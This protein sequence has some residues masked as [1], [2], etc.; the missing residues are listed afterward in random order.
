MVIFHS[1]VS[2]PEGQCFIWPAMMIE[3]YWNIRRWM[4]ELLNIHWLVCQYRGGYT[5]WFINLEYFG[6]YW[7]LAMNWLLPALTKNHLNIFK[8]P[9]LGKTV[10]GLIPKPKNCHVLPGC[11]ASFSLNRW[12]LV[13]QN[14]QKKV[15]DFLHAQSIP[16]GFR[17][18]FFWVEATEAW[19]CFT[20]LHFDH[21]GFWWL[22]VISPT[23]QPNCPTAQVPQLVLQ[24]SH[25]IID[26]SKYENHSPCFDSS[27]LW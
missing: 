23:N 8:V 19:F 3:I 15:M 11:L 1:Y 22:L 14:P 26:K 10:G 2:L 5:N 24:K 7:R 16:S 25:Q 18:C 21:Q 6:W 9:S 12:F 13:Y 17:W 20:I 4:H 27:T